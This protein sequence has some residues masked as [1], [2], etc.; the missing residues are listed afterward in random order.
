MPAIEAMHEA[1]AQHGPDVRPDPRPRARLAAEIP[2]T[3]RLAWPVVLAELGWMAMG[4]VDL[5]MVGRLGTEAIGAVGVANILYFSVVVVGIG[6]LVGLDTLISQAFGAGRVGDCHRWLVQ[7]CYLALA[8]SPPSIELILLMTPHL[9]GWGIAPGVARLAGTYLPVLAWSTP[10][11]LIFFALRRYLQSMSL[12]RAITVTLLATNVVNFAG[13]WLLIEGRLG[14]P[15]LG[16]AGSAWSTGLSRLAM[17]LMLLAYAVWH[18]RR[19]RTGLAETPWTID[20]RRQAQ[21]LKLGLPVAA[22]L[23]L[24][25]GVFTIAAVLAGRLGAT[26]LA[27]HEVVLNAASVT[28]MVPL[29]IASAGAVRVG[30]AVGRGD[31]RGAARAGWAALLL[32]GAFMAC[33]GLAFLLVPRSI[34]SIFT[35]QADVVRVALPLLAAAAMFQLFDG[36]QVVAGGALRGSGDTRTPM[37]VNLAAHWTIGLPIGIALAFPLGRGITGLWIGL[38]LGLV[39][40]GAFLLACWA[41]TV[42]KLVAGRVAAIA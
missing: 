10:P 30:Q 42:R 14:L 23:G 24:E 1:E 27:A 29:G 3:L 26:A 11:L 35:D 13:N 20:W 40:A 32:G 5:I 37:F 16:V 12:V 33:S 22:Q 2:P 17:M 39:C 21:L 25:V 36:L 41:L 38:S 28:F 34:L 15:R 4:V 7:G 8:I 9:G 6:F 18:S 19:N 31:P